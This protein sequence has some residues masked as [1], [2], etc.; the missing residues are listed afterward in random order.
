[1]PVPTPIY[2]IVHVDNV[3]LIVARGAL[4]APN[5]AP[6]DGRTYV[7]IHDADVQA[8]R[9]RRAV[10]CGRGG[11]IPDY[12]GFYFG[13]RSPM[14]Y[15]LHTGWNVKRVDQSNI[16]YL[17]STVQAIQGA[18][19]DFV[20]TDGHGLAAFTEW[21][22]DVMDLQAVDWAAVNQRAWNDTPADMDRQRRKQAEFH[23]HRS[24]P[25]QL[26]ERIGVLNWTVKERVDAVLG[27][28]APPHRPP[29]EI[30]PSW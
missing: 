20:F 25:W 6:S 16:V 4:H 26:I 15:R 21:Y 1:M 17:V 28:L 5:H 13:H 7:P 9:Q 12:V 27:R 14:L 11:T 10:P 23:V 19:L 29:V 30:Q 2:R 24:V 18:G 8:S 22:H 3:P